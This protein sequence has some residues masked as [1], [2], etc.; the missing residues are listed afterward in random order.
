[1]YGISVHP[2]YIKNDNH[3]GDFRQTGPK[4]SS[5]EQQTLLITKAL[6]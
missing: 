5:K 4:Y 2:I 1:M 3:Q 6:A